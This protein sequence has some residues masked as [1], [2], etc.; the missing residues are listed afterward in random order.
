[1]LTKRG[2]RTPKRRENPG[3]YDILDYDN[4]N[5]RDADGVPYMNLFSLL[6]NGSL[7]QRN[8]TPGQPFRSDLLVNA[9]RRAWAHSRVDIPDSHRAVP[10]GPSNPKVSAPPSAAPEVR[11]WEPRTGAD[12]TPRPVPGQARTVL[13]R[14]AREQAPA[15]RSP[16]APR[17]R[18]RKPR[19]PARRQA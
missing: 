8:P 4:D 11:A 2:Q 7:A 6:V 5:N 19:G 10:A 15:R 13:A 9:A 18:P 12:E 14:Q 16:G 1:M 3:R 17:R